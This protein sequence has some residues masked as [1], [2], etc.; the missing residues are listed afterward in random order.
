MIS[1]GEYYRFKNVNEKV[2]PNF[3]QKTVDEWRSSS[4]T[5]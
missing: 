4:L 1:Y 5:F 3:D 2:A